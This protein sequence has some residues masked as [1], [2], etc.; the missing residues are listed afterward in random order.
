[1]QMLYRVSN[2]YLDQIEIE[3][4]KKAG[5]NIIFRRT[6]CK[7]GL[8]V[9]R[10]SCLPY[11]QELEEDLGVLDA[12]LINSYAQHKYIANFEYYDDIAKFTAKTYFALDQIKQP[13][14]KDQ[15]FVL[16]GRTN[17]RKHKWNTCMLSKGWDDTV[18][19][20]CELMEDPFIGPQGVIIRE[21]LPLK[22]LGVS[23]ITGQPYT[24]EYR[25]WF[26]GNRMLNLSYY[27]SI[28]PD[29]VINSAK[30][31]GEGM[32]FAQ[33]VA[34]IISKRVNF[35]VLDI[36]ELEDG[37]WKLIEVNDGQ[38]SG[39]PFDSDILMYTNLFEEL[40]TFRFN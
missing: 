10:Y 19:I 30:M 27:W 26:L 5:F 3:A 6:D 36:A 32:R 28:A 37:S 35:F 9:A 11:Y 13:I 39:L 18:R 22:K 1:M 23:D 31:N 40:K 14:R 33:N 34:N 38:M 8:V 24:N 29:E 15:N 17:S 21:Y 16:K 12:W 20:Y 7:E 4:A 2:P 25:F